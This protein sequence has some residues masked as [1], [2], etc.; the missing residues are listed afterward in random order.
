MI[1]QSSLIMPLG[2]R[3]IYNKGSQSSETAVESVETATQTSRGNLSMLLK[4]VSWLFG[5]YNT[6]SNRNGV[7]NGL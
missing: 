6:S 1:A 5:T 4:C 2:T 3:E 7:T